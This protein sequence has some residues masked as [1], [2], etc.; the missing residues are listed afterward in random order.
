MNN[1]SVILINGSVW[2]KCLL[3]ETLFSFFLRL[4]NVRSEYGE[5]VNASEIPNNIDE[6]DDFWN[7]SYNDNVPN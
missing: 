2:L 7:E 3:G 6:I 4:D 1:L 5:I